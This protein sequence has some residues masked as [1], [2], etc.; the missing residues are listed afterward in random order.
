MQSVPKAVERLVKIIEVG[1]DREAA[2]AA[3]TLLSIAGF[4][5]HKTVDVNVNDAAG[6]LRGGFGKKMLQDADVIDVEASDIEEIEGD[7]DADV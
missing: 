5:D 6:V 1:E 3:R 2:L 4:S 7:A